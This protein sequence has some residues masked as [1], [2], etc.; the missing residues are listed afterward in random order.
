MLELFVGIA[1]ARSVHLIHVW[2]VLESLGP[3]SELTMMLSHG[4]ER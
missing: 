4:M 3:A 1:D 2:E